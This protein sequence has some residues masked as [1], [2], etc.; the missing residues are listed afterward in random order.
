[1]SIATTT[2]GAGGAEP[3]ANALRAGELLYLSDTRARSTT[4]VTMDV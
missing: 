1:M 4:R 3:Y 2:F